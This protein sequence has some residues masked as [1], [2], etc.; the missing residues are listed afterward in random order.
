MT[1]TFGRA[2]WHPCQAAARRRRPD[3]DTIRW[4][5]LSTEDLRTVDKLVRDL[6][7]KNEENGN[8]RGV[9]DISRR[10]ALSR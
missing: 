2:W 3:Y 4:T 9:I 1:P 5:S 7:S 6:I 10:L 8:A